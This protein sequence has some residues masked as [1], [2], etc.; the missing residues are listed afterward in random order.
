MAGPPQC[1]D[2]RQ[3]RLGP[4]LGGVPVLFDQG[5]ECRDR[6]LLFTLTHGDIGQAPLGVHHHPHVG[7]LELQYLVKGFSCFFQSAEI[8]VNLA[9][10]MKELHFLVGLI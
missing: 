8:P 3:G 7:G 6:L 4:E 9:L 10:V 5:I 2:F 1:I